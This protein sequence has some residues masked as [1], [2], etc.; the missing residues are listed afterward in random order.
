ME[1][2]NLTCFMLYGKLFSSGVRLYSF[3]GA[4]HL[5]YFGTIVGQ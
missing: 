3:H 5:W 4:K 1:G 2:S